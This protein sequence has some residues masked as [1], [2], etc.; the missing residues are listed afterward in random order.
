MTSARSKTIATI[1]LTVVVIGLIIALAESYGHYNYSV[2]K[3]TYAT[4]GDWYGFLAQPS[5]NSRLLWE[6]RPNF[7]RRGIRTNQYGFRDTAFD[8]NKA[9]GTRRIAFFGDSV[10]LGLG[11]PFESTFVRRLAAHAESNKIHP[12]TELLNFSVDGYNA[13]QI[14]ESMRI[15]I[16]RFEPDVVVYLMCLNDI[17]LGGSMNEKVRYFARP[18]SFVFETFAGT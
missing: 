13:E 14:V 12:Q 18:S 16:K 9:D 6:Y 1:F 3:K 7:E 5:E 10:T 4:D 11:V 17:D 15:N 8:L 2:W